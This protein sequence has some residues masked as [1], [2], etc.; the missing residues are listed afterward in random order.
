MNSVPSSVETLDSFFNGALQVLQKKNG[1]RFSVDAVLLSQFIRI[2][3]KEK[4]I[5]LGTGCGIIPLLLSRMSKNCHFVGVEIQ[6]DLADI[7]KRNVLLN[8]LEN[9]ISIL[10]EDFRKLRQ[11]FPPGSFDLVFSNPPYRRCLTGRMNPCSEKAIARHEL[12]A[13]LEDLV[14]MASYLLLPKGRYYLIYAA[15]RTVDL[16]AALRK[17]N[18]EPKRIRFV[19]PRAEGEAKF[20]LVESIKDSGV[21]LNVMSPLILQRS[22]FRDTEGV[23]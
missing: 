13:T 8:S 10:H 9:R 3:K 1:Y 11:T 22:P 7:A 4:S 23:K 18:L 17:M 14:A 15:S 19:H 21:E 5:D 20:V 12:R 16:L 6:K 2:R